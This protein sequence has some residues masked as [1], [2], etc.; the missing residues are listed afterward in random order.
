MVLLCAC[1]EVQIK[2]N[3]LFIIVCGSGWEMLGFFCRGLFFVPC[4][5]D[6]LVR[7]V[8]ATLQEGVG[9]ITAGLWNWLY[10]QTA[11]GVR[12]CLVSV[13]H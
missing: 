5:S 13:V 4:L 10:R 7:Y 12:D 3:A 1:F 9:H 11:R 6:V 8:F 2:S